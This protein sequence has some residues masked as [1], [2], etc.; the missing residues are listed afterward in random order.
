MRVVLGAGGALENILSPQQPIC[1][2]RAQQHVN[3]RGTR[4]NG[5]DTRMLSHISIAK[6][7]ARPRC[8]ALSLGA[9]DFCESKEAGRLGGVTTSTHVRVSIPVRPK[10]HLTHHARRSQS[11]NFNVHNALPI[12]LCIDIQFHLLVSPTL[13]EGCTADE[14]V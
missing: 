3:D 13:Q 1:G 4:L 8:F 14:L 9:E 11:N 2:L 12:F 5:P 7:A 6:R 10:L